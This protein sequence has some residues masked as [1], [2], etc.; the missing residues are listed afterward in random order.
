MPK[1]VCSANPFRLP[2]FCALDIIYHTREPAFTVTRDTQQR[3]QNFCKIA[4]STDTEDIN[5]KFATE[6]YSISMWHDVELRW[7]IIFPMADLWTWPR[8]TRLVVTLESTIHS[9]LMIFC[10]NFFPAIKLSA[11]FWNSTARF[12]LGEFNWWLKSN[13]RR[14]EEHSRKPTAVCQI[15]IRTKPSNL[16]S[17]LNISAFRCNRVGKT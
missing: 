11:R 9:I 4:A 1:N 8:W 3:S 6:V 13:D 7:A 10:L 14:S 2:Y 5:V 17:V 12:H 16:W 15:E